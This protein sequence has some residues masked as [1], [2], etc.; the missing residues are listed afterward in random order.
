[1]KQEHDEPTVY[2]DE[3]HTSFDKVE[4]KKWIDP[5]ASLNEKRWCCHG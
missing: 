3:P 5:E 1:M 2:R 4:V